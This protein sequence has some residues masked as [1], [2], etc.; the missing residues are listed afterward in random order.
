MH[1]YHGYNY[2]QYH[3]RLYANFKVV[4]LPAAA[5]HGLVLVAGVPP[6]CIGLS[7]GKR[8]NPVNSRVYNTRAVWRFFC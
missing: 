8:N 7:A 1:Y 4:A 3:Q 6:G 5:V 2:S